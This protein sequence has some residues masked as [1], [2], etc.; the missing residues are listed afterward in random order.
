MAERAMLQLQV[1]QLLV[2]GLMLAN[3]TSVV[4][5]FQNAHATCNARRVMRTAVLTIDVKLVDDVL[6]LWTVILLLLLCV[7]WGLSGEEV[8][9]QQL[10]RLP[11]LLRNGFKPL[12]LVQG[13]ATLLETTIEVRGNRNEAVDILGLQLLFVFDEAHCR[14]HSPVVVLL[15]QL[16]LTKQVEVNCFSALP[17]IGEGLVS[18][19][20][21]IRSDERVHRL[22]RNVCR[23]STRACDLGYLGVKHS[24]LE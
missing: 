5:L 16:P 11:L 19:R 14:L 15:I 20:G 10:V 18:G 17:G 24:L 8:D 7:M 23:R 9:R 4:L 13:F 2:Q 21:D 1:L 22:R 6:A 3:L 12:K